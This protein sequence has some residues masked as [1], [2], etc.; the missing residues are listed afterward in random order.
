MMTQ[1]LR[2]DSRDAACELDG[3]R[4]GSKP[5]HEFK[6]NRK[7]KDTLVL[8][9]KAIEV[10]EDFQVN[11]F[12]AGWCYSCKFVLMFAEQAG[13]KCKHYLTQIF[14]NLLDHILTT[15]QGVRNCFM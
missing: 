3:P 9:G 14:A 2:M 4:L 6:I 1:T 13:I 15:R 10:Q 7:Y 8:H 11:D 5:Q 12:C